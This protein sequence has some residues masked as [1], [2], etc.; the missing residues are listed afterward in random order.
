MRAQ[1]PSGS[2]IKPPQV[3]QKE[4]KTMSDTTT[5]LGNS[6]SVDL[7]IHKIIGGWAIEHKILMNE[8]AYAELKRRIEIAL[9]ATDEIATQQMRDAERAHAAALC[10]SWGQYWAQLYT[11]KL[12]PHQLSMVGYALAE[13]IK[14]GESLDEVEKAQSK[15][16]V[17]RATKRRRRAS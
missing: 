9:R 5:A 8:A 7:L 4:E 12:A 17:E 15:L 1:R 13:K 2:A 11:S 10:N 6:E 16:G 14:A 3:Y